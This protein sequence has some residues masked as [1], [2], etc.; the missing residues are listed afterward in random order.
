MPKSRLLP[1]DPITRLHAK[2]WGVSTKQHTTKLF[3]VH[4]FWAKNKREGKVVATTTTTIV[5]VQ[6]GDGN[7]HSHRNCVVQHGCCT[8]L[9]VF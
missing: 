1:R 8:P 6:L 5:L 9:V 2:R 7:H 3:I 4:M